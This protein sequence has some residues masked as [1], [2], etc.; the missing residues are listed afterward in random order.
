MPV[1][2]DDVF[3]GVLNV[4]GSQVCAADNETAWTLATQVVD[5]IGLRWDGS[6]TPFTRA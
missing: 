4:E 5:R 3:D 2:G 6:P 1:M